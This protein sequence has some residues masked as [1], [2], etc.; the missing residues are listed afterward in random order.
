MVIV[1]GDSLKFYPLVAKLK[2]FH[3]RRPVTEIVNNGLVKLILIC[4]KMLKSE[5]EQNNVINTN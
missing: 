2:K 4:I 3:F 5:D 1:L